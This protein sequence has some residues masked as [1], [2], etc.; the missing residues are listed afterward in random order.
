MCEENNPTPEKPVPTTDEVGW[1]PFEDRELINE[2]L[3]AL[4]TDDAD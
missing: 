2:Y 1:K 4:E 3:E